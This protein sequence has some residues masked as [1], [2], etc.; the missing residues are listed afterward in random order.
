[1]LESAIISYFI[2]LFL[3]SKAKREAGKEK[4]TLI[5]KIMTDKLGPLLKNSGGGYCPIKQAFNTCKEWA[6]NN[7]RPEKTLKYPVVNLPQYAGPLN[8]SQFVKGN[9]FFHF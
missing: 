9:F 5:N 1:M 4:S 8:M 6:E 7:T 2:L 3:E